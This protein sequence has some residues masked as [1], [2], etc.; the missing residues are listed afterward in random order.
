MTPIL[1]S[2][3]AKLAILFSAEHS[4][5]FL[6]KFAFMILPSPAIL[7]AL[8]MRSLPFP[9]LLRFSPEQNQLSGKIGIVFAHEV[10]S[11][12]IDRLVALA[13]GEIAISVIDLSDEQ[14]KN[15]QT[16]GENMDLLTNITHISQR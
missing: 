2:G 15:M 8:M 10:T 9:W 6:L 7:V 13:G 16:L 1:L 4:L 5:R 11:D 12:T 14:R 3:M